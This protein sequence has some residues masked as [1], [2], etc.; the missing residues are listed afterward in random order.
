[1]PV[2]PEAKRLIRPHLTR[3][4]HRR[5]A[6]QHRVPGSRGLDRSLAACSVDRRETGLMCV[7]FRRPVFLLALLGVQPSAVL[8]AQRLELSAAGGFGVAERNGYGLPGVPWW[9][10]AVAWRSGAWRKF[11][12]DYAFGH[13][14]RES[15]ISTPALYNRR[16]FTGSVV[17]QVRRGRILPLLQ[18]VAGIQYETNNLNSLINRYFSSN[19]FR[20]AFVGVA[21]TGL[22]VGLGRTA[23]IRPQFRVS[24]APGRN[25]TVN[26]TV[27]PGVGLG[28]I[29]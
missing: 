28:W 6:A 2:L 21:G 11:Q 3:P 1:M 4:T 10:A 15:G 14:R 7:R 16:F 27:L 25:R 22:A 12:F 19:D 26:T 24:L 29:F 17:L 9:G 13:I 5:T 18:F 23:F 20:T 8:P